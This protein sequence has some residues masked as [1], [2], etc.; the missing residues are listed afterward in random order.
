MGAKQKINLIK[1]LTN[2]FCCL[3]IISLIGFYAWQIGTG[4]NQKYQT[5]FLQGE[6]KK[7]KTENQQLKTEV[8]NLQ[9]ISLVHEFAL[10]QEMTQAVKTVYLP[11]ITSEVAI[12]K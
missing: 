12:N 8:A 3:A 9:S 6:I 11:V 7:L 10:Q 4:I 5:R 2:F 1:Y